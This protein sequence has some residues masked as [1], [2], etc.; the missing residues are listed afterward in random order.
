MPGLSKVR[1]VTVSLALLGLAGCTTEQTQEAKAPDVDMEFEAGQWPKYDVKWADVDVGTRER[2]VTVPVVRVEQ[3]TR[4]VSVPYLDINPPAGGAREEQ[5]VAIEV[6]VPHSGHQLQIVEVRAAGDA[7]WVIG[8]LTETGDDT[9][10]VATRVSD[11]VVVNAPEDLNIRK[12]VVG[13]RPEGSYNQ[14]FRFVDSMGALE[15][16]IPEGARVLYRRDRS[17]S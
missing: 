7:L 4:E 9:T 2:T 13:E 16:R 15:Q 8:Q 6:D 14:Q 5:T 11:Q 12:V 10:Q 1:T 17:A 3:E